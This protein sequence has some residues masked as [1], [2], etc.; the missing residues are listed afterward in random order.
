MKPM[1][2][3]RRAGGGL[4]KTDP[5]D[6]PDYGPYRRLSAA[7]VNRAILDA[8]GHVPPDSGNKKNRVE[9]AHRFLRGEM[10]PWS[11]FVDLDAAEIFKL[12]AKF[13]SA[14]KA[15]RAEGAETFLRSILSNGARSSREVRERSE[16][17]GISFAT[18]RRAKRT[19]AVRARRE[20]SVWLWELPQGG[21]EN[22][23]S[24]KK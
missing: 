12:L 17:G 4:E 23:N 18:L 24:A 8:R 13:R 14:G 21:G 16:Q 3:P 20:G 10:L 15:T 11:E 19:L 6:P 9:E 5:P 2:R 7:V 1:T 22:A